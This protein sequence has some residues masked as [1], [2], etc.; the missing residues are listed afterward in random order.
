MAETFEALLARPGILIE[1]IISHGDVTPHDQPHVQPHDEW[2]MVLSGAARLRIEG[3][4]EQ[5]LSPGDHMLVEGGKRHWVTFTSP[6]EPTV[7]LAV[8]LQP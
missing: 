2:V 3:C 1:R 7:W 6:N 4:A 8:H 5:R